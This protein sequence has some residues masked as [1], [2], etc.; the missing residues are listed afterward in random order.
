M[1][2]PSFYDLK[3]EN[4]KL[5]RDLKEKD[6]ALYELTDFLH[7]IRDYNFGND[8]ILNNIANICVNLRN[9]CNK[10]EIMRDEDFKIIVET[11]TKLNDFVTEIFKKNIN[12]PEKNYFIR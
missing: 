12:T 3:I 6:K 10:G 4:E 11:N 7:N 2:E 5:K 8:F 1:K 9:T